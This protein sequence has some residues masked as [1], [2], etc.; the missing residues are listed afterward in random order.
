MAYIRGA[1]GV[2]A[3]RD[4]RIRFLDSIG[5]AREGCI[6]GSRGQYL[7]VRLDAETWTRTLHPTWR[8]EYIKTP[9]V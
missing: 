9:T 7:R 6:V 2:P 4:G 5:G 1:Y 3:K 8:I